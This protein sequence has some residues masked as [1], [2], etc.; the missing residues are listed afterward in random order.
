MVGISIP[1]LRMRGE[2]L[3]PKFGIF[4]FAF[5]MVAG[6]MALIL[7]LNV[8]LEARAVNDWPSTTGVVTDTWVNEEYHSGTRGSAA[9]YDYHPGVQYSYV[10]DNTTYS[11]GVISKTG[12]GYSQYSDAQNYIDRHSTGSQIIVYY[13]A[14]HP[15][16]AV[17]E[18]SDGYD[19][20]AAIAI[21]ALFTAIGAVGIVH[22]LRKWRSGEV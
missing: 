20:M 7:G 14:D 2:N 22:F 15:S 12:K 5:F 18:K 8:Y 1:T 10:V 19:L 21:G 11:G 9:H 4:F 3:S 17:L 13:D 6:L 16:D